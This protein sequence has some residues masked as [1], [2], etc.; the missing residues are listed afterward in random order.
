MKVRVNCN[1]T[2]SYH[3]TH[4]ERNWDPKTFQTKH[5]VRGCCHLW[6]CSFVPKWVNWHLLSCYCLSYWNWSSFFVTITVFRS[7]LR[8]DEP[9]RGAADSVPS[10][11]CSPHAHIHR[12]SIMLH[13]SAPSHF[14]MS[15]ITVTLSPCV[16]PVSQLHV[17]HPPFTRCNCSGSVHPHLIPSLI[18]NEQFCHCVYN[19]KTN[20][21]SISIIK[22]ILHLKTTLSYLPAIPRDLGES[23]MLQ[24]GSTNWWEELWHTPPPPPHSPL[25]SVVKS[26]QNMSESNTIILKM[27][28]KCGNYP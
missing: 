23:E 7:V 5:C 8:D 9:P 13:V 11:H 1:Q 24:H 4:L 18:W 25:C 6:F 12:V 10:Y 2:L 16:W 19:T 15:Q 27:T 3:K 17:F 26:N 20:I 22:I 28:W 21:Y 14:W